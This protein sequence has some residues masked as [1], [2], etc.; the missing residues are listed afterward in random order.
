MKTK[1]IS[2]EKLFF[3]AAILNL[4]IFVTEIVG[5][6]FSAREIGVGLFIYYTELSNIL[7]ALSSFFVLLSFYYNVRK[8]CGTNYPTHLFRFVATSASTLTFL[9][10]LFV[11]MPTYKE[12]LRLLFDGSM[13]FHHTLCPLLSIISFLFFEK[14]ETR[15]LRSKHIPFAWIFT[16]LYGVVFLIL[17]ICRIVDGPYP[18]LRVYDQPIWASVLWIALILGIAG[19]ISV[20]LYV[21][22]K[23]IFYRGIVHG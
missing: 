4:V 18:F 2:E 21:G 6:C 17:N 1:I 14:E 10:V 13:F 22:N 7:L 20:L 11:L 12:P 15:N 3:T 5:F 9:V 23:K 19:G 16:L 8:G